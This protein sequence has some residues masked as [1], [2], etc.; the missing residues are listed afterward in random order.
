MSEEVKD[1]KTLEESEAE[2]IK[3]TDEYLIAIDPYN[4]I[5]RRKGVQKPLGFFGNMQGALT[6]V[7]DDMVK[8]ELKDKARNLTDAI[9]IV[10]KVTDDFRQ[11]IGNRFSE[12]EVVKR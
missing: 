7:Y 12:Y 9:G 2:M 4:Y 6:C 10:N 3:V 1:R 5:A 11:I 8:R